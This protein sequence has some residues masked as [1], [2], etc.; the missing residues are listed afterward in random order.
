MSLRVNQLLQEIERLNDNELRELIAIM[1]DKFELLGW[2]KASESAFS[3]WDNEEDSV[4]DD[5][6]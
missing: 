5:L 3:D 4:Y 2:L 1:A 6:N